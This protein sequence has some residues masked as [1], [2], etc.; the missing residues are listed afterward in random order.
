MADK[1][2]GKISTGCRII[3]RYVC[4]EASTYSS[5]R[6]PG[7]LAMPLIV[8]AATLT[9][10]HVWRSSLTMTAILVSNIQPVVSGQH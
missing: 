9:F 6:M 10:C 4:P 8:N 1:P 7:M 3:G 5:P 2:A